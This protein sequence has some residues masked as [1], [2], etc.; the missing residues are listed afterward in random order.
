MREPIPKKAT[1]N[2]A[3]KGCTELKRERYT[4]RRS[5]A[6]Y[7]KSIGCLFYRP[8]PPLSRRE[9]KEVDTPMEWGISC[10]CY[11]FPG[12]T[13]PTLFLVL[14]ASQRL[15]QVVRVLDWKFENTTHLLARYRELDDEELHGSLLHRVDSWTFNG[16]RK[17]G[18]N[19]SHSL[20]WLRNDERMLCLAGWEGWWSTCRTRYFIYDNVGKLVPLRG[21]TVFSTISSRSFFLSLA[22]P[23]AQVTYIVYLYAW[24]YV[25]VTLGW[26]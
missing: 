15:L 21:L 11:Q 23:S 10:L 12:R 7:H 3:R 20:N 5:W 14:F 17:L 6:R 24:D 13:R 2:D 8:L 4:E 1:W 26:G 9:S 16:G 25:F 22:S 18:K 19:V